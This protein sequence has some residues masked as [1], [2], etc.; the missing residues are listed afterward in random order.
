[1]KALVF[2]EILW[3]VYPDRKYIGGASLN[4]AAHL[5]KHGEE[6]YLLS[7]LG[8]DA[9]G[10][11]ALQQVK[12]F[13]I[14]TDHIGINDEKPTG[15]CLVTLDENALPSYDLKQDVAYDFIACDGVKEDFDVLYFGT[16]ALRNSFNL[17]ALAQLLEEKRFSDVLVDVN[18][19]APFYSKEVLEFSLQHATVL[20]VSDEELPVVLRLLDLEEKSSPEEFCA[21]LKEKYQNLRSLLL[22]LGGEGARCYDF[23]QEQWYETRAQKVQV[24]STVGA[25]DSF[26]AA[27]LHQLWQN[28][29]PDF[30]L[31]YAARVA[32]FVVSQYDAVPPYRKEEFFAA[33]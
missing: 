13:G 31:A 9:L 6:V 3:D 28:Q 25:G 19:R 10:E 15:Q 27:F 18:I 30:A 14:F 17:S 8:K 21:F 32:G 2:G 22:T 24:A 11:E 1:M 4:F 5:A 16:L 23:Q 12:D 7:A 33:G 26:C 20:K 29:A